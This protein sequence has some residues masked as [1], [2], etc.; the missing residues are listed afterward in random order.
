MFLLLSCIMT[1]TTTVIK[2]KN[3]THAM[4][5]ATHDTQELHIQFRNETCRVILPGW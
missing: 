5:S 2:P 1:S 3:I 4:A